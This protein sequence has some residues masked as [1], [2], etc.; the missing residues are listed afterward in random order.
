[1]KK[2]NGYYIDG[3][4]FKSAKEIDQFLEEQAVKAY[5]RACWIFA[6][7]PSIEA[8]IYADEKASVLA[9]KYGYTWEQIEAIELSAY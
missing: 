5:K 7:D 3:V 2:Y 9:N 6:K 4:T 8:S 1:M